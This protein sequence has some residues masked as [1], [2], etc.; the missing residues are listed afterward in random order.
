MIITGRLTLE[1]KRWFRSATSQ[2]GI[3][4]LA[5]LEGPELE[6]RL[7]DHADPV[8]AAA[9]PRDLGGRDG[10]RP[11]A[12][13]SAV[14]IAVPAPLE[15]DV[16]GDVAL[17]VPLDL[18]LVLPLRYDP[19]GKESSGRCYRHLALYMVARRKYYFGLL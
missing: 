1:E 8:A 17:A 7:G 14:S 13:S 4:L 16:A 9:P 5:V 12:V 2:F 11:L 19:D 3:L 6:G 18:A 10:G 15:G